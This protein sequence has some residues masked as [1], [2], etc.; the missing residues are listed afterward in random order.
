MDALWRLPGRGVRAVVDLDAIEGNASALGSA[1]TA[2][3]ILYAVVKANGYGHGAIEVARAALRGGA[4]RLAVATVGEGI[5]LRR[6]GIDVPI[7]VM[8]PTEPLE[9]PELARHRLILTVGTGETVDQIGRMLEAT[10]QRVEVHLKV[11][12]GMN[13][14]GVMPVAAVEVARQVAGRPCFD[15]AGIFS[16][17]SCA[18]S[19]DPSE[20]DRQFATFRDVREEVERAVGKRLHGHISNS[21][22]VLRDRAY[23][24]DGVRVGIA[25]YGIDP[26]PEVPA[27]PSLRPAMEIVAR[28]ARVEL[29]PPG[30]PVSYGQ[31][32]RTTRAEHLGLVPIG[33]ADGYTRLLSN[34]GW[35]GWRGL[36]APIRGRVCM[37]QLVVGLPGAAR[38]G[39]VVTVLGGAGSGAP[40]AV[41]L[42]GL[43]GSIPYEIVS[44]LSPRVPRCY[45]RGG[46]LI[47]EPMGSD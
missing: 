43:S 24:L 42:A 38:A 11:D 15:L 33:Y 10:G 36:C 32:Y 46:A 45:L 20:T 1:L 12:T 39:E 35:M 31:T 40:D 41:Q 37:D 22:A 26:S 19:L 7:L 16:H 18:D 25:L 9:A 44:T 23:D 47:P 27:W 21:G 34:T 29:A 8:G 30:S 3:S 13:R 14:F 28:L 4:G 5:Q 6:A 2:G 17:F